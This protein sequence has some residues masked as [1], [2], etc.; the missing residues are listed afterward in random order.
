MRRQPEHICHGLLNS[1]ADG[2]SITLEDPNGQGHTVVRFR[3]AG[4]TFSSSEFD[5][6][7]RCTGESVIPA[8]EVV[9]RLE[10][11]GKAP[12]PA[13]YFPPALLAVKEELARRGVLVEPPDTMTP[14]GGRP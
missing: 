12:R 5:S 7:G 3:A 14:G 8:E 10:V 1:L 6:E 9:R 2:D 13:R 11:V 4:G